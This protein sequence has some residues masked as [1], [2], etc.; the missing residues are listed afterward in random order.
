M[1]KN[2]NK[3]FDPKEIISPFIRRWL[4]FL[5]SFIITIFLAILYIKSSQT[6]YKVQTSVL[7]KDAKKMSSASGDFGVLQSLGGFSGMATNSIEN[8]IEIFKSKNIIYDV[9][10]EYNFQTSLFQ[11]G[12]FHDVELY[13]NTS[14]Y[15][16]RI[17]NEK[18]QAESPKK[19]IDVKVD[20]NKI[21]LSSKEWG[22]NIEGSFDRTISLP[23]ANIII[24]KN[25]SFKLSQLKNKSLSDLYFK[26]STFEET[27]DSFQEDLHVDLVD[28]ESTVLALSVNYPVAQKGKDFLNTVVK[29]YNFYNIN[30]KN[31]ESQKTKDFIDDRIVL[32][33]KQLGDVESQK[34]KFKSDKNIIDLATEAQIDLG[35]KEKSKAKMLDL[36]TQL[37]LNNTLQSYLTTKTIEDIL[38]INVGLESNA[39]KEGIQEY[40]VLVLTR[41]KL[42]E[43]AT[44]NNPLV[45]DLE[46]QLKDLKFSIKESINKNISAL[47]LYK[48]KATGEFS[49]SRQKIDRIPNQERLFRSIERQQ[50]IKENLYLLLLQKR[51]EA[52]ISMAITADK[53]R[54]IDKAFVFKK[55]V[56]PKKVVTLFIALVL[57]FIIPFLI[58]YIKELLNNKIL[59]RKDIS[60]HSVVPLLGE[61]PS[62][63]NN[64]NHLVQNNDLS[65]L[66]E[67]F[68]ILMTNLKYLMQPKQSAH[69]IMITSSVKGEG[70]TLISVNL[71]L[72]LSSSN[73]KVLV[74]GSDIRNPQLQRYNPQM[75]SAKGLSEYLYG[76]VTDVNTI[77]HPSGFHKNCDFIYSGIIPPNP[78]DLL[79]NGKYKEL[80]SHFESEYDFII[81]DTAPLMPVTDSFLIIDN[82]DLL[83]YVIRSNYSEISYLEFVNNNI[84]SNKIKNVAFVLNDVDRDNFGYG[85][86][87]GY[88]YNAT[89][90]KWWQRK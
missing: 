60:K 5:V 44:V 74:I 15:I 88:G 77:V 14:P 37:E 54:V 55:P 51:E 11:K 40:N 70:K 12:T 73:K 38:P 17:I 22:K 65:S 67:S 24:S 2:N 36:E 41:N 25:P 32:I 85:N 19:P 61:I 21:V 35:M 81:M 31:I 57:G 86:Q 3:E 45:K 63:K 72:V 56:S 64:E 39:A 33:S 87:Y 47:N 23:F 62:L 7:I 75:K 26:Y 6:V 10:K 66:A 53:A 82:A 83:V 68:R 16:F 50:Q 52:A 76:E 46:N 80:V 9:L 89:E 90:R 34:E 42:M 18:Q 79:S 4:W 71:A 59:S 29:Q 49:D 27:V 1:D 13:G 48:R 30:D 28:K 8:E 43:N 78:A 20:G 84:A 58:I 69:K